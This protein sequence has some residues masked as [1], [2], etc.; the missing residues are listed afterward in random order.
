[1]LSPFIL[2]EDKDV[3]YRSTV[4]LGGSRLNTEYKDIASRLEVMTP[5]FLND[6]GAFTVE[7]AFNYSGNTESPAESWGVGAGSGNGF[8]GTATAADVPSRTRGLSRTTSTRNYFPTL[9][10]YDTYNSFDRGLTLASGPNPGLF[11]LGSPSGIAN[12]DHNRA[13]LREKSGAVRAVVDSFGTRRTDLD[14]NMPLVPD[15]LALRLDGL[16]SDRQYAFKGNYAEDK[17]LTAALGWAPTKWLTLDAYAE[18]MQRE[19]SVPFYSLPTDA[20]TPWLNPGIGN[21]TP[22]STPDVSPDAANRGNIPGNNA[23]LNN[24]VGGAAD[25]PTYTFG[26]QT[27]AGIYSYRYTAAVSTLGRYANQVLGLAPAIGTPTLQDERVY[28]FKK[29]GLFGASRPS[30]F[31]GDSVT[32]VANVK[33]AR[34]LYLE[35]AG[36]FQRMGEKNATLYSPSDIALNVD[37]NSYAYSAGYTPLDP[38]TVNAAQAANRAANQA[39]R[40]ANP[41]FGSLYID[42]TESAILREGRERQG[43]LSLAYEFTPPQR[44]RLGRWAESLLSRQRFLAT[45]SGR[46]STFIS[47]RGAR[48]ILDNV[49]PATGAATAPALITAANA[50]AGQARYM[51]AANRAF[52]TRQYLDPDDPARATGQL[53]FDAFGTWTFP[54]DGAGKPFEV[55]LLPTLASNGARS[56]NQSAALVYQGNFLRDRVIFT[57]TRSHDQVGTKQLDPAVNF[58]SAVT[59]LAP[60]YQDV[61]WTR[62]ERAPRF[63][64][65]SRAL[66]GHVFDWLSLHY[67]TSNNIDPTPPA[68]HNIDG[69]LNPFSKGENKEYGLRFRYRGLGLTINRFETTQTDVDVPNTFGQTALLLQTDRLEARYLALQRTRSQAL[70]QPE[71]TDYYRKSASAPGYNSLDN[72]AG[73]G[74]FRLFGDNFARGTEVELSGRVGK[75]DLRFTAA[76]TKSVK[77]NIGPGWLQ[78][79]VDPLIFQRMQNV[80]WYA[81][82]AT[83]GQNR[84]V[85]G[86]TAG[87]APIFGAPGAQPLK[88]WQSVPMADTGASLAMFTHFR[89]NVL[90]GAL[91]VQK[92]TGT[93]NPLLREWRFNGTVAV[94]L[95]RGWRAGLSIRQRAKGLV[96]YLTETATVEIAGNQVS[97]LVS[98]IDKPI[99]NTEQWYFD[100][101]VSYRGKLGRKYDFSVQLN[102]VNALN[103]RNLD[104]IAVSSSTANRLDVNDP[105]FRY[106]GWQDPLAIPTTVRV[107]DPVNLQLTVKVNF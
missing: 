42:G 46:D 28:P 54:D 6:I 2:T 31:R 32:L 34:D 59:G 13:R 65:T 71:F 72:G 100:P 7:Q 80:E 96:G 94:N 107:Q 88:G 24:W 49:N 106:Y 27:P 95:G 66:V 83:S 51:I 56:S 91:L 36:N 84:P 101:F 14:Y 82:D 37:P 103:E 50:K 33:L 62:F 25:A 97:T 99:Y 93:S 89:Q 45:L 44:L 53:P 57:Y 75:F 90:P 41:D 86:Q 12:T 47:Q 85:V 79:A 77:S 3:G 69:A 63:V 40:T 92:L 87:N 52:R 105:R 70:G 21:R 1:M 43:R 4:S 11:G 102:V 67:Y 76:K 22:F 39:R 58:V 104:M 18:R 64:N 15:R 29:Y 35:A 78:Y 17:R 30:Q 20:I 10:P 19:T 26:G 8:L 23:Y 68:S 55:G 48:L 38:I 60:R 98:N 81:F 5:D 73:S 61:P 16:L 9:L 74:Y